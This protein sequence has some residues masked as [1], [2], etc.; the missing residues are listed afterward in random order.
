MNDR[1]I[2]NLMKLI[3]N[4]Y[5]T[6][7]ITLIISLAL[8]FRKSIADSVN[9]L[10]KR[11]KKVVR[12]EDLL[13]HNVF[14]SLEA[15]SQEVK[16]MKFYTNKDY[17]RVKSIM[18]YD[19]TKSKAKV[20]ASHMKQMLLNPKLKRMKN[21]ELKNFIIDAQNNMHKEYVDSVKEIWMSKG[22]KE[23]D[24]NYVI[25]LF[26]VFRYDVIAS[27]TKSIESIFGSGFHDT[28][29][30]KILAVLNMWSMG[31]HL[32]PKDMQITFENLNGKFKNINY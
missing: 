18:C 16:V 13:Q 28:N 26:E 32:L 5:L 1:T 2:L 21:I 9:K 14:N 3:D 6:S 4:P 25:H 30:D 24:V 10:F 23:E 29:F 31:I 11:K 12:I 27:F 17:D 19:F 22:I 20:C 7:I 8:I 15:V